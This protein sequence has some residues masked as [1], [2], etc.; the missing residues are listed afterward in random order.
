MKGLPGFILI[1]LNFTIFAQ[2][3]PNQR[4][5][6]IYILHDTIVIDTLSI[7]P[8]SVKLFYKSIEIDSSFYQI[9]YVNASIFIKTDTFQFDTLNIEYKVFPVVLN[10]KHYIRSPE[11][12]FDT[13]VLFRAKRSN[14]LSSS[15][16]LIDE[17]GISSNGSI[18][19]GF[20]IGNNQGSSVQSNL[21][22]ELSGKLNNEINLIAAI[23]DK[24]IP[25]QPEG[26]TQQ[27]N[28]F[29][30]AYINL[31]NDRFNSVIGDFQKNYNHGR[32]LRMN[33]K[34]RGAN[35]KFLFEKN[36]NTFTTDL[37]TAV[38][39]GK[40]ARKKIEVIEGN[41]GPYKLFGANNELYIIVLSGTERIYLD[42]KILKRGQNHDYVI[43]YNTAEITFT[44]NILITKDKRII[45]EYEYSELNYSKFMLFSENRIETKKSTT[46][47]NIYSEHES[48]NQALQLNLNQE[49]INALQKA[50]D[51]QDEARL[52]T[53]DSSSFISE[54]IRYKKI[55]LPSSPSPV[56]VYSTSPDSA[57]YQVY[58]SYVGNNKGNY[59]I[60][61]NLANGRIYKWIKPVN[62][63]PQG[64]YEPIR[65]IPAPGS[66]KL[67]NVASAIH[68]NSKTSLT[69]EGS[70]S[71]YD[72][73]TFSP[74]DDND[75][76]G[77]ALHIGLMNDWL[78]E[79]D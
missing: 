3:N 71:N 9:D 20:S 62:A 48:K 77:Y 18:S 74:L 66:H 72:K 37:T 52:Y 8:G 4:E 73:N 47:I 5:K 54:E 27:I 29:D 26:Y 39:K 25:I 78:E 50:G 19:R 16:S 12:M 55:H 35:G 34:L 21:N 51:N 36:G 32:F 45:A 15:T 40:Y 63:T 70:M 22:L 58:F 10:Q 65:T 67:I 43:N 79:T 75:N 56:F 14:A 17:E 13:K 61:K 41:Q 59:V 38:M 57:F 28:E 76:N 69:L 68:L 24:N 49:A 1:L 30:R 11:M 31:Y 46:L 53:Y 64:N 44:P 60:D 42:G 7:V 33:K 23:S 2:S 6:E